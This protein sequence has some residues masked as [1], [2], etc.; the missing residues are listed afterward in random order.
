MTCFPEHFDSDKPILPPDVSEQVWKEYKRRIAVD[1]RAIRRQH[2]FPFNQ[3]PQD[4]DA[5]PES[6]WIYYKIEPYTPTIPDDR[7]Q[8]RGGPES[9]LPCFCVHHPHCNEMTRIVEDMSAWELVQR[10]HG[11]VD[12]INRLDASAI[13]RYKKMRIAI[14]VCPKCEC[15]AQARLDL[16]PVRTRL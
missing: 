13:E 10:F 9:G 14:L 2:R 8:F 1:P 12:V 5:T 3:H 16:L 7:K 4:D 15:T 11:P 6:G